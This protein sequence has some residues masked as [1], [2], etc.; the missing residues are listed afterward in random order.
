MNRPPGGPADIATGRGCLLLATCV[1]GL[2]SLPA[3]AADES[4]DEEDSHPGLA[5][6]YVAG[7]KSIDRVDRDVEFVWGAHSPDPRLA[8]GPF[9]ANWSGKLLVRSEGRH[10]FHLFLQG[11]AR[12]A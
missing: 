10:A 7:E 11:E 4:D 8:A 5:A 3:V 1:L 2:I 12:V 9:A 6:T